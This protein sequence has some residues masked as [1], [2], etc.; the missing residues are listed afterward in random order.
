MNNIGALTFISN[1]FSFKD[2]IDYDME[3]AYEVIKRSEK[4]TNYFTNVIFGNVKYDGQ[5]PMR[6]EFFFVKTFLKAESANK[7]PYLQQ[8]SLGI[9]FKSCLELGVYYHFACTNLIMSRKEAKN[10]T[11]KDVDYVNFDDVQSFWI[12]RA[13][14]AD[15]VVPDYIRSQEGQPLMIFEQYFKQNN[16]NRVLKYDFKIGFFNM[17][18]AIRALRRIFFAG[19]LLGR[20]YDKVSIG[21]ENL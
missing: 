8:L 20:C 13:F 11:V 10:R 18:N 4:I 6:P 16:Y 17:E 5:C 21:S 14:L 1:I 19:L 15:M 7:L 9:L 12:D 3:V 2:T